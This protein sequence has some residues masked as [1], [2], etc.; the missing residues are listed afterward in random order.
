MRPPARRAQRGFT[1]L[2]LLVVLVI[3]GIMVGFAVLGLGERGDQQLT[4]EA[5]R[6]RNT[7]ALAREQAMLEGREYALGVWR[8]GY[9]FYE[10]HEPGPGET[11]PEP[12]PPGEAAPPPWQ[13]VGDDPLLGRHPLPAG[14]QLA[15]ELEGQEVVLE[16]K[17]PDKPQVFL[18]S[19]GEMTPVVIRLRPVRGEPGLETVDE[20]RAEEVLRYD[21][22]G[23]P[24]EA[25]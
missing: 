18:L 6:L 12:P 19:S 5:N 11:P 22:L 1:L 20:T 13:P 24:V 7:I 25:P 9:G 16:R 15:L 14:L 21:L 10:L 2:E 8:T 4:R 17:P 23:R 3:I